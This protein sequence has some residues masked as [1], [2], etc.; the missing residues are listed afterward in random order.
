MQT[1]VWEVGGAVNVV[2]GATSVYLARQDFVQKV[3]H[4]IQEVVQLG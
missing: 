3:G 1:A 4:F 2:F